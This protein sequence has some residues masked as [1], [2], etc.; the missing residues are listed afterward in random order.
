MRGVTII[1]VGRLKDRFYEDAAA[2]YIK[3]LGRYEKLNIIEVKASDLPP[4]AS[5]SDIAAALAREEAE[6]LKKIPSSALCVAMCIEGREYS[7]EALAG[8]IDS[9]AGRGKSEICF[10]I[11]GS[12]GLSEAVKNRCDTRMS[13]SPMT[14][15]HRLAR[16]M[17]LEQLYRA[18]KII[19]GEPYHK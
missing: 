19:A 7:S 1:A 17:L 3:R 8:F 6:I 13:M 12:F 10:I 18:E 14:F 11:G 4:D 16:I 2:E 15:P 5:D 9:A